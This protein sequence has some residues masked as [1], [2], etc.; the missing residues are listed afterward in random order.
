MTISMEPCPTDCMTFTC[1]LY[2]LGREMNHPAARG[3]A[4]QRRIGR[5]SGMIIIRQVRPKWGAVHA[6]TTAPKRVTN[7]GGLTVGMDNL[8]LAWEWAAIQRP[9]GLRITRRSLVQKQDLVRR[10]KASAG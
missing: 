1:F 9:I 3:L 8:R 6:P 7:Q 10:Y 5:R 2:E 4:G